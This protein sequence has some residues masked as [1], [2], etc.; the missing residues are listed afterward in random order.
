MTKSKFI[1][2]VILVFV[3]SSSLISSSVAW[4]CNII[5]VNNDG[6][7]LASSIVSY[8]ASGDGSEEDPYV[9]GTAK[10]LYN[11][12]WLQN[13]GAFEQHKYYF[14][15]CDKDGN[16][17]T[18][19]MAGQ[20]SGTETTSGAIPPIGTMDN[21]FLGYFDGCGSVI[22]NLWISTLKS[23]WKEQPDGVSDYVNL[24]VGMFGV[25]GGE[26]I[27]EDFVLDKVEVKSH[28]NATV[29]IICGLVDAKIKNVRVHNGSLSF[30]N[31]AVCF[32]KYSLVGDKTDRITWSDMPIL[33]VTQGEGTGNESDGAG[34]TIKFDINDGVLFTHF[35]DGKLN[36]NFLPIPGAATDR[37]FLVGSN[38]GYTS[39]SINSTHYMFTE[40][41][42]SRDAA[43]K[44]F[45]TNGSV[46]SLGGSKETYESF[47]AS[48][49]TTDNTTFKSYGISIN[50]DF[51]TRLKSPSG[52]NGTPLVI[53]TTSTAPTR[54]AL[55]EVTLSTVTNNVADTLDIPTNSVWFK[56]MNAGHCVIS[57]TVSNMGGKGDKYRSIYRFKR[58]TE[59]EITTWTETKLVFLKHGFNNK[60]LVCFQYFIDPYD[61][62][63]GYEFAIG[64]TSNAADSSISFYFLALAGSSVSGGNGPGEGEGEFVPYLYDVDFVDSLTTD[65]TASNYVN[66]QVV[67][68]IDQHSVTSFGKIHFRSASDGATSKV[69]Y[70]LPNNG[71]TIRDIAVLHESQSVANLTDTFASGAKFAPREES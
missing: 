49:Y 2:T 54:T 68:R 56:P 37:A 14:K 59:G 11:F 35:D 41:I 65:I 48:D 15:V 17:I 28:L 22:E 64:A 39:Q 13:A 16:P 70:N 29:G 53:N 43:G 50:E 36:T 63:E 52:T 60:D 27:V 20:I 67:L 10:H 55:T 44:T 57:F 6:E 26:A 61:V 66:H 31:G 5:S 45:G 18:L 12:A 19:D 40:T 21:P 42:N 30:E 47:T 34:G 24:Y 9:I 1:S 71:V 8:F 38:V 4:F 58:N 25:I 33:D 32:S 62:A 69:Y 51:Q 7:F 46:G 3:L 23:D